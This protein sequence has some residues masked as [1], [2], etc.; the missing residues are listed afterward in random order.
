M[1]KRKYVILRDS[2]HSTPPA[3]PRGPKAL[4]ESTR[5]SAPAAKVEV[6]EV[7][8]GEL[9]VLARDRTV[10]AAAP[11]MPVRLIE[12]MELKKEPAA[13]F[14]GDATW[15]LEAIGALA[16]PYTGEGVKVA[17]LDTGIDPNHAAFAG[18]KLERVNYTDE[19]DLDTN[20][21]GTHCAGTIFGRDVGGKRIGV[22]PGVTEAFIGKVLGNGGGGSDLIARA[23][24]DA[25]EAGCQ[26]ISM[27]L[28]ID[29]PGYIAALI[30]EGYPEDF[31]AGLALADYR[32]NI[33]LFDR[34]GELVEAQADFRNNDIVLVAAAGNEAKR[35]V[36]P[37]YEFPA[38][39][40]SEA[41][42]FISVGAAGVAGEHLRVADF[43]NTGCQI[44]GPGVGVVSA[45]AGTTDGL[46]AFNGT[47]M[48]TPHVAGVAALWL[49]K[50][51][52]PAGPTGWFSKAGQLSS[53]L[54]GSGTG[55]PFGPNYDAYDCGAGLVRC[56]T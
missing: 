33:R 53:R 47:S 12:P 37:A 20:G 36:D 46:V 10:T 26:V 30:Q 6:I 31:A 8:R 15:G 45:R 32:S 24:M 48:A 14:A 16:S 18:V 39:P 13:T 38:A 44:C 34:I 54:L 21:H 51:R 50:L 28:G 4:R 42:G 22:A 29:F 40:P 17:V 11:A 23:V 19:S 1:N 7:E 55:E 27:S 3:F 49:E 5:E 52:P 41:E 35:H 9:D 43:S 2:K 56:P 25:V